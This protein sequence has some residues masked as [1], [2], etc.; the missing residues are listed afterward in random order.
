MEASGLLKPPAAGREMIDTVQAGG[1][2]DNPD[3]HDRLIVATNLDCMASGNRL[4]VTTLSQHHGT[5]CYVS[6]RISTIHTVRANA[7]IRVGV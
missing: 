2:A 3:L 5:A 7:T 4:L 1:L 6:I